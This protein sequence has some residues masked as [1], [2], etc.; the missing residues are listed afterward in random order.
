MAHKKPRIGKASRPTFRESNIFDVPNYAQSEAFTSAA[1]C[2]MM[3]LKFL[4]KDMR[5][6]KET[7]F[8]IWQ[9]AVNGSVWH[10]S[11]YGLAYALAKRGAKTQIVSNSKDEG[12]E[13]KL[14]VY[15]GI[16]LETLSAS[17]TEIKNKVKSLKISEQVGN[18]T[19]SMI[20][21]QLSAGKIP[22]VL[23]NAN[24]LNPYLDPSPHWVV[25]KGYDKDAVYIN[26]PY[27]ANTI[28]MEQQVFRGALGYEG[29]CHMITVSTRK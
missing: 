24:T 11:R 5:M 25:I 23:V 2:A 28:T 9:E 4:N 17:F 19:L 16:N 29:E 22:I 6:R 8:E 12:Y 20:K 10:G 3:A 14:A 15:E 27:S 18:V 7:E 13:K 21:K 26:D 1:A